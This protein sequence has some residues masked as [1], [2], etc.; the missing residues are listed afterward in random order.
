MS[1][2]RN[3]ELI[4]EWRKDP[5]RTVT[6]LTADRTRSGT[7]CSRRSS[8]PGRTKTPRNKA[9]PMR[10]ARNWPARTRGQLNADGEAVRLAPA[11]P[12]L[13][14][15]ARSQG[16]RTR[17]PGPRGGASIGLDKAGARALIGTRALS[18]LGLVRADGA[19][20]HHARQRPAALAVQSADR[21]CGRCRRACHRDRSQL[22]HPGRH[23]GAQPHHVSAGFLGQAPTLGRVLDVLADA[24]VAIVLALMA[25][26][27]WVYAGELVAD[28]RA[29]L[30]A[31]NPGCAVLV[32]LRRDLV[33][34]DSRCNAS[35]SCSTSAIPARR[36]RHR[37]G[38]STDAAYAMSPL[39]IGGLGY[40]ARCS[41]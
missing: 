29:H 8:R 33:D 17:M 40:S 13:C 9:L 15:S 19:R 16:P 6:E 5:K 20:F 30:C 11:R 38:Q 12:V 22:L 24:A 21:R 36:G 7:R 34:R 10:C 1:E 27:F 32:C 39:E 31:E 37:K 2:D 28:R 4:A 41:C 18:V 26:Q 14:Q 3:A 23:D 35:S 25:W